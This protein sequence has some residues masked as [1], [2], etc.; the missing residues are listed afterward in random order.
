VLRHLDISDALTVDAQRLGAAAVAVACR[1]ACLTFGLAPTDVI[2]RKSAAVSGRA[3][4]LGGVASESRHGNSRRRRA[5]LIARRPYL[6]VAIGN[7][8]WAAVIQRW[9][10]RQRDVTSGGGR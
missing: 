7:C 6:A 4:R 3:G 5:V 1:G 2:A 10:Q 9:R 8:C